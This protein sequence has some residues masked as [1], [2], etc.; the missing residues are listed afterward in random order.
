MV[1]SPAAPVPSDQ[2]NLIAQYDAEGESSSPDVPAPVESN[3]APPPA[4]PLPERG[5]DG[6]F[7][8][9]QEEAR[10]PSQAMIQMAQDLGLTPEEIASTPADALEVAVYHISRQARRQQEILGRRDSAVE[11]DRNQA[12]D[13]NLGSQGGGS[14]ASGASSSPPTTQPEA[15]APEDKPYDL[16]LQEDQWDPTLMG[17]LKKLAAGHADQA[18]EIKALKQQIAHLHHVENIRANESFAQKMDRLFSGDEATFGKGEGRTLKEDSDELARRRAVLGAMQGIKENI[19]IEA[20]YERAYQKIFGSVKPA[21]PAADDTELAA[22]QDEWRRG[23]V[24]RPTQ[25]AGGSEPPGTAKATR[26][27]AAKM[28]EQN[29]AIDSGEADESDFLG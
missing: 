26:S 16:G 5:P 18:K 13:R 12:F 2:D 25:R 8:P 21:A 29:G 7:L 11:Q 22:R 19:S 6:K 15:A 1:A 14:P 9:R 10:K 3:P 20:K 17:A 24:A 28:A 27:V 23:N 4:R